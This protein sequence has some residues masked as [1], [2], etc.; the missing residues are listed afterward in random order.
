M[1]RISM[2][3]GGVALPTVL[4]GYRLFL[5]ARSTSRSATVEAGHYGCPVP[6]FREGG[7]ARLRHPRNLVR[8]WCG[9]RFHALLVR[10][11]AV[12]KLGF[13]GKW[14]LVTVLI[15]PRRL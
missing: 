13:W 3:Y 14:G 5:F 4:T 10:A 7:Q 15:G 6:G 2:K 11:G 9:C 1:G 12:G 8:A